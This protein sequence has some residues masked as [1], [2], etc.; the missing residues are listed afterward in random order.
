MDLWAFPWRSRA[1]QAPY[2]DF[3]TSPP[4]CSSSFA[5]SDAQVCQYS[6]MLRGPGEAARYA[7][8][9]RLR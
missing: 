2:H 1:I 8:I 4:P 5:V 9:L 6:E 7:L 3:R